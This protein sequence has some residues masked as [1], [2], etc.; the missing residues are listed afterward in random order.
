MI[1]YTNNIFIKVIEI[2]TENI[3]LLE[4]Y[5]M[6]NLKLENLINP[7]FVNIEEDNTNKDEEEEIIT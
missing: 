7:Y 6:I 4:N 1:Q 3:D 5:N 2:I